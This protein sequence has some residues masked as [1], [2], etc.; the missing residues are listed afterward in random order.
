MWCSRWSATPMQTVARA[1]RA[2]LPP[3]LGA[4]R[5][6]TYPAPGNHEYHTRDAGGY[7]AY[8]GA[9]AT[10][11]GDTWHSFDQVGRHLNRSTPTAPTSAGA[12]PGRRSPHGSSTISARDEAVRARVLASSVVLVRQARV[13]HE[14]AA[15]LEPPLPAR[16]RC[17][18][19][20]ARP[21]LR[22][23]HA[24][25]T[26]RPSGARRHSRVRGHRAGPACI[27]R[28]ARAGQRG[29]P[30]SHSRRAA[31][32]PGASRY[33]WRFLPVAGGSFTDTGSGGLPLTR[34]VCTFREPQT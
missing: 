25:R 27:R 7:R 30:E 1:V 2:A 34:Y 10:P 17:R 9:R 4:D 6:K 15:V 14:H 8:F 16:R 13:D 29:A 18:L 20:R 24:T 33:D 5:G 31:P 3:D 22:A 28:P 32:H 26:R 11:A 21:F 12:T 23:V 19:G